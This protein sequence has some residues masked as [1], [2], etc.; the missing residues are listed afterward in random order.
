VIQKK[1]KNP[2]TDD[3]TQVGISFKSAIWYDVVLDMYRVS[4]FRTRAHNL[5]LKYAHGG[6]RRFVGENLTY[7]VVF[8]RTVVA[9]T[10]GPKRAAVA[11]LPV[12]SAVRGGG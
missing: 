4:Y 7:T 1:K 3:W 6:Y 2:K 12:R 11:R 9:Y 8:A 5:F 10:A